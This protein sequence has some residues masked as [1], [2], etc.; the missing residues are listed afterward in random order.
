MF[1]TLFTASALTFATV[2][3]S[4]LPVDAA[5]AM[6]S[7]P[8]AVTLA[9]PSPL[10]TAEADALLF[11][12]EEEKLAHDVYVT[13]YDLW[14][15]NVF[16]NI[17]A[18]EQS[19]MDAVGVLL[20]RYGLSDPTQG[21]TVGEFTNPTLQSLY[22]QLIAQGRLSLA[23]ALKVGAQIE[24]IDIVDLE[25]RIAVTTHADIRLVFERLLAGSTNHL[26][27]FVST[28]ARQTGEVY[29]PQSMAQADYD[30]II[31]AG[32]NGRQ[33]HGRGRQR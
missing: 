15:V 22:D 30:A 28:L 2:F 32:S 17:V 7:T 5:A 12:R 14:G 8:A 29:A 11:M 21:N 3:A 19:H 10:S 1:K 20:D 16:S 4:A 33:A 23:D 27:A 31:A 6:P 24:E 9:A 18:S 25:Q 26:R 13:L